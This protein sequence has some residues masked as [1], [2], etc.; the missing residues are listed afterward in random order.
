MNTATL[1]RTESITRRLETRRAKL[2]ADNILY[3]TLLDQLDSKPDD[4]ALLSREATLATSLASTKAVIAQLEEQLAGAQEAERA[5]QRESDK[6]AGLARV[7]ALHSKVEKRTAA[8]IK[9]D[10]AGA[11]LVHAVQ[12]FVEGGAPLG[13]EA[14]SIVRLVKARPD[15]HVL[16]AL[17]AAS[18][19]SDGTVRAIATILRDV[20]RQLPSAHVNRFFEVHWSE[21][22]ATLQQAAATNA[23]TARARLTP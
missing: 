3:T 22:A 7:A 21:G 8:Y 19:L 2:R 18:G 9:I 16:P 23:A 5:A 14:A 11:A 6:A 12:E 4:E 10:D 20:L 17:D 13:T 1:S 15:D